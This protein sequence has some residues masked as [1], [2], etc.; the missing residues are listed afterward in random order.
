MTNT[1]RPNIVLVMV[2]QQRQRRQWGKTAIRSPLD[3][4]LIRY[5]K[6]KFFFMGLALGQI[7]SG[8]IWLIIDGLTGIIGHCIR[9]Y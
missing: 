7:T 8:G 1:T 6:S 4:G 5:E 9:V 3:R 2:D